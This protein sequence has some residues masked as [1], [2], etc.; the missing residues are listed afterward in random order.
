MKTQKQEL[1]EKAI[2]YGLKS[3]SN[4]ELAN[5]VGYKGNLNELF[6]SQFFKAAKELVR[7]DEAKEIVKIKSSQ[8]SYKLFSH[9]EQ[10]SHEQFWCV[11]LKR[12]NAIIKDEFISKGGINSAIVDIKIVLKTAINLGASAIVLCHNHPSGEIRPSSADVNITKQIKQAAEL[13]DVSV[14]DHLII[15]NHGNFYS[16][17]D[18]GIM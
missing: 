4:E 7:R 10:L 16:F 13:I 3:L 11:Y 18:E 17:S 1:S 9:L 5:L 14:L 6:G 15:G 8:D 2:T 12:N